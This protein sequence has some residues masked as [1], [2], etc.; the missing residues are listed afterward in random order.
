MTTIYLYYRIVTILLGALLLT[1][2]VYSA[3]ADDTQPK[4]LIQ[5]LVDKDSSKWNTFEPSGIEIGGWVT[6]GSYYNPRHTINNSNTPVSM[7]DRSGQLDL[8]QIDLFIEKRLKKSSNWQI[9]G[10]FDAMFGSDARYTQARGN[11]DSHLLN[12]S[13]YNNIALPQAYTEIYAPIGEGLSTKI[14]HFYTNM[15]YEAVQ[16]GLNFYS[17][18]SYSF[19]ASPLTTT[20]VLF[21]YEIGEEWGMHLGAVTGPD[22]F[23]QDLGAWFDLSG[24]HWKNAKSGTELSISTKG[25]NYYSYES[26]NLFYYTAIAKQRLGKWNLV[27]EQVL[28]NQNNANNLGPNARWYSLVPYLSYQTTEQLMLGLR[29]EWFRDANGYKYDNGAANYYAMTAGINWTPKKWLMIRPEVRYD[30]SQAQ[31][32]PFDGGQQTNQI[33]LGFDT[34]I[35]F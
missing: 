22:N 28:A 4:G 13:N 19:R 25:G 33:L 8:Y 23:N 34:V 30:W 15:D 27:L 31:I 11:W 20:G 32:N 10:R 12:K 29:G 35:Q 7:T 16:S 3:R 9:G 6:F 2:I 18:H 17:S 24:I 21:N 26:S 5:A 14:G 1:G